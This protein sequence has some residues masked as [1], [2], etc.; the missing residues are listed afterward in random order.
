MRFDLSIEAGA[1]V[2]VMG[3]SGSGKTT[4]LNL[5]AG[6][7]EPRGRTCPDR[8]PRHDRVQRPRRDPSR[9]CFRKT[10]SLPISMSA[11]MSGSG[12]PRPCACRRRTGRT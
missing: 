4:L 11:P 5:I 2:A 3:A 1:V 8:R 9:W 6:F 7:E 10:T 12:A